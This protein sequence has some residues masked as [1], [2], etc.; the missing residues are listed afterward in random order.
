MRTGRIRTKR[1]LFFGFTSSTKPIGKISAI[2]LEIDLEDV[3]TCATTATH[4]KDLAAGGTRSEA[5]S[6]AA[7]AL[8]AAEAAGY[9]IATLEV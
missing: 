2:E 3:F 1:P 4:Q 8:T 5:A 6:L 7:A 9:E